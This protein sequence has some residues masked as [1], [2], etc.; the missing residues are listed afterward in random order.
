[1]SLSIE[2]RDH[3]GRRHVQVSKSDRRYVFFC[4][5]CKEKQVEPEGRAPGRKVRCDACNAACEPYLV[6]ALPDQHGIY[7]EGKCVAYC[8]KESDPEIWWV[9]K[10]DPALMAEVTEVVQAT[11]GGEALVHE[12]PEWPDEK[13]ADE[14]PPSDEDIEED[15]E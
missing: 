5:K 13:E 14:A 4:A 6:P 10:V 9:E 8:T 12:K 3:P 7:L 1:M 2:L 11:Y 15:S